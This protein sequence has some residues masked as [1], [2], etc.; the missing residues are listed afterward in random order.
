MGTKLYSYQYTE[1]IGKFTNKHENRKK[2]MKRCPFFQ[3]LA[4]KRGRV[5]TGKTK[6]VKTEKLILNMLFGID[7][8]NTC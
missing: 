6:A 3:R 7:D 2:I 8:T 4:L 1:T 5:T